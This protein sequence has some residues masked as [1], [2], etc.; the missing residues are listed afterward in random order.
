[1]KPRFS[2]TTVLILLMLAGSSCSSERQSFVTEGSTTGAGME[3]GVAIASDRPRSGDNPI[4]VTVRK[5]GAP[6]NDAS[7]T[8]VFSMPAMPSM[9]MPEMRSS[10]SLQLA[11]DGRYRGIGQLSMAGTWNVRVTVTQGGRE[12]GTKNLSIVAK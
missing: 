4:D 7:V 3:I 10:A 11:G 12:L 8:A 6:V 5:D 9:N 2:S 1:M